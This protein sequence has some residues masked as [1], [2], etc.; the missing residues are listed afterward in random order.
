MC[1]YFCNVCPFFVCSYLNMYLCISI[2][3]VLH[4]C[5]YTYTSIY[6]YSRD[7]V[8]LAGSQTGLRAASKDQG[9]TGAKRTIFCFNR[10]RLRA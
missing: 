3:V 2:H 4:V 5:V 6:A 10:L 8:V 9:H 1:I 7:P